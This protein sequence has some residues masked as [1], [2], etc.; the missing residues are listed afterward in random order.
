MRA[1]R[2]PKGPWS[3]SVTPASLVI[4]VDHLLGLILHHLV[5]HHLLRVDH[6]LRVEHLLKVVLILLRLNPVVVRGIVDLGRRGG[7]VG[8]AGA[9]LARWWTGN[10]SG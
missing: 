10:V 7:V 4:H 2:G 8:D 6:L 1:T 3:A 9:R 5:V